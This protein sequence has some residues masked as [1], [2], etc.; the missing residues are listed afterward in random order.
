MLINYKVKEILLENNIEGLNITY[1][2][3]KWIVSLHNWIGY[4][5]NYEGREPNE[6]E[7]F[8]L[9]YSI[10]CALVPDNVLHDVHDD[11]IKNDIELCWL[12]IQK[13]SKS[14]KLIK[15]VPSPFN[16][17]IVE[18]E[19]EAEYYIEFYKYLFENYPKTVLTQKEIS[20]ISIPSPLELLIYSLSG[21]E[22]LGLQAET[23]HDSDGYISS[24]LVLK[25]SEGIIK[26]IPIPQKDFFT[27]SELTQLNDLGF[28]TYSSDFLKWIR[29]LEKGSIR[30]LIL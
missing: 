23:I 22:V 5:R 8:E 26:N 9:M 13:T 16:L 25:N 19:F 24:N 15:C 18:E 2:V 7:K 30:D 3:D 17:V 27:R 12:A 11:I 1:S 6:D 28:I 14:I 21:F 20:R 4:H 10:G 29:T